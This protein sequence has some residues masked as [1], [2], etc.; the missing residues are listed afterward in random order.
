MEKRP[1]KSAAIN[2]S[3]F[4]DLNAVESFVSAI[5]KDSV[6]NEQ[7]GF[8]SWIILN[9]A[10][11]PGARLGASWMEDCFWFGFDRFHHT[12]LYRLEN[13][14]R[15]SG[16]TRT[17][18]HASCRNQIKW[19]RVR[20]SHYNLV[21]FPSFEALVWSQPLIA[22]SEL[23]MVARME[24]FVVNAPIRGCVLRQCSIS[25]VFFSNRSYPV[26]MWSF[27]VKHPIIRMM[28]KLFIADVNLCVV[29]GT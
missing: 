11:A 24:T 17:T 2:R 22:Q 25:L 9:D 1:G 13:G 12:R 20:L 4:R 19:L 7:W 8:E 10:F 23:C 28:N 26:R 21:N 15:S 3:F 14:V 5:F 16:Y 18:M 29:S 27:C 6:G